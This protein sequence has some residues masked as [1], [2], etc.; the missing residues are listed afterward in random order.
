VPS[1][2]DCKEEQGRWQMRA[3]ALLYLYKIISFYDNLMIANSKDELIA[4]TLIY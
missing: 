3:S 4:K 2:A 1:P